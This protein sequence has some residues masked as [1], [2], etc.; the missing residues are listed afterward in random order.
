MEKKK[1]L[2]DLS[3]PIA[4]IALSLW[5]IIESATFTGEEGGFLTLIGYFMLI[6]AL[7][8]LLTTLKQKESKVNFKNINKRKVIEVLVALALYVAMFK[9]I[10]YVLSTF[11]L[12][13]FVITTLGYKNHKLTAFTSAGVTLVVF[14]LFKIVL[15]VPLPLLFLDF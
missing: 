8:I 14:V 11:L 6:V 2:I 3:M 4:F 7:F 10:G 5:M 1:L 15:G 12:C 13:A 9:L